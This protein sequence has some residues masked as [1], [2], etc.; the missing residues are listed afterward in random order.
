MS[1][2]DDAEAI[3]RDAHERVERFA[4]HGQ[5]WV[6]CSACGAVWSVVECV[7]EAG[8]EW[9]DLEEVST[10]DGSCLDLGVLP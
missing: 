5:E 4:E 10:G 6:G 9:E 8:E 3:A 1:R 7:N 2:R